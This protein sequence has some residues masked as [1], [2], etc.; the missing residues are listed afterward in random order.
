MNATKGNNLKYL[1]IAL[2]LASCGKKETLEVINGT[3]GSNGHSL[4]SELNEANE[5]IDG[6][7]RLDIFLDIDDNLSASEG[8]LFQT[9][10]IACNGEQGET[11]RRGLRG[12]RGYQGEEGAM[13]EVGPQG[14]I[15]ETGAIG[16]QGIQ[17]S[18]GVAG[19]TGP[20]GPQGLQGVKGDSGLPAQSCTLSH[21]P[22][23]GGN[24]NKW[25]LTCGD[26]SV[27]FQAKVQ[28]S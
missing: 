10:L 22:N 8:D 26:E 4:V 2:L 14:L 19:P 23:Q 15:G 25:R 20:Q 12:F 21:E 27:V 13:G 5:C 28:E 6:G 24:G 11:G 7:T 18:Q 9:S 1:L 16:P 3:N 17:G